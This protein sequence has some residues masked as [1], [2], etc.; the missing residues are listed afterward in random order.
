MPSIW[1]SDHP[2][3]T[4]GE[5]FTACIEKPAF[6]EWIKEFMKTILTDYEL[7]GIVWDEPKSVHRVSTH[8]ATIRKFGENPTPEDMIGSFM[9]FFKDLTGYCQSINSS[10]KQTLFV[11]KNDP[12]LFT[13]Q[14]AKL[15]AIEYMGYDGNLS[16]QSFFHETPKWHKYRI[17]S[18]WDRTVEECRYAGKRHLLWSKTC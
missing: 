11:Q 2:E 14:A 17:E 16:R 8:P 3:Q 12:E 5:R 13:T 10:L 15:P 18:V 9:E 4:I 7:D 6:V 1:L